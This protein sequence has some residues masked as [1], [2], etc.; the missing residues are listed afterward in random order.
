MRSVEISDK[1]EDKTITI[2]EQADL[3]P[4]QETFRPKDTFKPGN[5]RQYNISDLEIE[6][7]E[8]LQSVDRKRNNIMHRN[9]SQGLLVPSQKDT[10]NLIDVRSQSVVNNRDFLPQIQTKPS[11]LMQI[12]LNKNDSMNLRDIFKKKQQL[13]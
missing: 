13:Q 5:K 10:R 4:T 7:A 6:Q 8:L 12:Y 1:Q 9:Q 11:S 3:I 2:Q